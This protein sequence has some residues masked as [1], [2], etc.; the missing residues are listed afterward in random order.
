LDRASG[1]PKFDQP[2]ADVVHRQ[3]LIDGVE[4]GASLD[5]PVLAFLAVK[6]DRQ[7]HCA[8][9]EMEHANYPLGMRIGNPGRR[10]LGDPLG[11]FVDGIEA[12]QDRVHW[13]FPFRIAVVR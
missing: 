7:R 11:N 3:H 6:T 9:D 2:V 1:P 10:L 13:L 8:D 4:T 12:T 5:V